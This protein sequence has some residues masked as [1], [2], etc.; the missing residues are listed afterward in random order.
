MDG[1]SVEDLKISLSQISNDDFTTPE[2]NSLCLIGR[3][4][5]TTPGFKNETGA[6][7]LTRWPHL[8]M[9]S[10]TPKGTSIR[11]VSIALDRS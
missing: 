5:E 6:I 11:N 1:H 3:G 9:L 7:P 2:A 4:T 8:I 10:E